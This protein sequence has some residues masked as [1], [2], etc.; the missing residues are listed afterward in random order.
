[1][2]TMKEVALRAGVSVATVSR[3][4]NDNPSV[5]G[6]IREKV[7][8]AANE[9][10]YRFNP[11]ARA[12]RTKSTNVVGLVIPDIENPFFTALARGIEDVMGAANY[13]VMFCNSDED[14]DKESRYLHD[15]LLSC[16]AGVIVAP[17]SDR[18]TDLSRLLLQ[19]VPVVAVDRMSSRHD[20][21]T[22]TVNNSSGARLA[23]DYLIDRCGVRNPAI[24][25][26]PRRT[27]TGAARLHGFIAALSDRGVDLATDNV[28]EGHHRIS[29]GFAAVTD[30]WE[31]STRPDGI[32]VTNNLMAVGALHALTGLGL[33]AP[34]DVAVTCFDDLLVDPTAHGPIPVI[35]QPAR[36]IGVTAGEML[37]RRIRGSSEPVRHVVLDPIW[38]PD[39]V[40]LELGSR[41][42]EMVI[43]HGS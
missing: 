31:R 18:A 33:R 13:S 39:P 26:G 11:M 30:L 40:A 22:V 37:L 12:L 6:L 4:L 41:A 24:I 34:E 25:T 16:V 5:E 2:T 43:A 9:M 17:A 3:V 8:E 29:G 28:I 10:G 27:S 21:D 35:R 1:M 32:F 15:L 7:L 19:S 23:A 38:V 14:V 20:I 42:E 36:E